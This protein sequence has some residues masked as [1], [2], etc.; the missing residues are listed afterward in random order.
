MN[1]EYRAGTKQWGR[2]N[3][4][5]ATIILMR[6]AH[7]AWPQPGEKDFDR[8]LDKAG[9]R[10]AR[11]M[12]GKLAASGIMPTRVVCSTAK[13]C[14]ETLEAFVAVWEQQPEIIYDD[15]LYA[16]GLPVY[17]ETVATGPYEGPL[18]ILGHN[19]MIEDIFVY[20]ANGQEGSFSGYATAGLAILHRE[21]GGSDWT[22]DDFLQ[23]TGAL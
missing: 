7:A 12:A 3:D 17:I 15:R 19:P 18:M 4:K 2:M 11:E 10:E 16:G 13:R 9:H 22:L 23:P 5:R 14:R 8:S 6:H 1:C 20:M 21:D